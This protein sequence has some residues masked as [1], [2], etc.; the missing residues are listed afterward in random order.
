M[1]PQVFLHQT[2]CLLFPH[3][4]QVRTP[5]PQVLRQKR[6]CRSWAR[7]RQWFWVRNRARP[8]LRRRIRVARSGPP[9]PGS[10]GRSPRRRP[11]PHHRLRQLRNR[12]HP[13]Q[14]HLSPRRPLPGHP[15]PRHPPPGHPHRPR[16]AGAR[17]RRRCP[18][19]RRRARVAAQAPLV[20]ASCPQLR[21]RVGCRRRQ[22]RPP[23]HCPPSPLLPSPV[24]VPPTDPSSTSPLPAGRPLGC[25]ASARL[26][27]PR[28]GGPCRCSGPRTWQ[29]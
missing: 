25:S 21:R 4:T 16:R 23:A 24:P 17:S 22:L 10:S 9:R 5:L 28:P 13:L 7:G 20:P 12:P 18:R 26:P 6:T 29:P 19:C 8:A 11:T 2:R 14:H 1:Y 3:R 27:G 15:S